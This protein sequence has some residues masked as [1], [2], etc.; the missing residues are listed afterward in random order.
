[1]SETVKVGPWGAPGG[2]RCDINTGSRPQRLNSITVGWVSCDGPVT[3]TDLITCFSFGYVD[4]N[5]EQINVSVADNFHVIG[6][7]TQ[8]QRIPLGPDDQLNF[9]SGTFDSSNG[10]TSL[11]LRINQDS[12]GPY[13]SPA[14]TAFSVPLRTG[15]GEEVAFFGR[16]SNTLNALGVYVL[17][18]DGLPVMIGPWPCFSI[19]KNINLPVQLKSVS[20]HHNTQ[21]IYGFSFSC[22]DQ[23]GECIPAGPWG[24]TNQPPQSLPIRPGEYVNN[25][26]GTFDDYGVTSLQFTTNKGAAVLCG[27]RSGTNFSVPLPDNAVAGHPNHNTAVLGFFGRSEGDSLAALGVYV[28][29][30]PSHE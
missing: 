29:S 22:I 23:N 8:S 2:Q 24:S 20:V 18:K 16:G 15:A 6:K 30:C 11:V 1:M 27:R 9:V 25:I 28:G 3:S 10:I 21:R 26:T 4:Q 7:I 13:G 14:G 12:Y 17:G 5:D 19:N